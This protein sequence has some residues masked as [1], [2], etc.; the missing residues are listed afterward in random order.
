MF[1]CWGSV[2]GDK[3]QAFKQRI[4]IYS[5]LFIPGCLKIPWAYVHSDKNVA[6][7]IKC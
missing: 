5:V 6:L 2:K 7:T 3:K 1:I 4:G